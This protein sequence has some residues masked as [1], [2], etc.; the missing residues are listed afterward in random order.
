VDH[1]SSHRGDTAK[2][3]WRQ[4]DS[5]IQ[6][7]H[8]PV[9]ASGLNQ[10]GISFSIIP[11]KLLTPHDFAHVEAVRLRLAFY[12]DLS[13]QSPTPF[14]WKFDRSKLTILLANIEAHQQRLVTDQLHCSEEAA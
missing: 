7:L 3:R 10:V 12:E 4:V 8:T 5:R 14:Q 2:P 1:G 13:N 9:H 6:V 11:R